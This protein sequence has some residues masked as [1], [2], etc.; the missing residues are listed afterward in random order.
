MA[1]LR[2]QGRR[3]G[4][5]AFYHDVQLRGP[6]PERLLFRLPDPRGPDP[7]TASRLERIAERDPSA[8][9]DRA[10]PVHGY[11]H[12]FA[13]LA[14][15]ARPGEA[16][17]EDRARHVAGA[18]WDAWL[19]GHGRYRPHAWAPALAAA[20]TE[21]MLRH[22]P[23]L[24]EGR[25]APSR[26]AFFG[27]LI[28]QTRH[29]ARAARAR[30]DGARKDGPG[31][32][33]GGDARLA[34][35]TGAALGALCLPFASDQERQVKPLLAAA[36]AGAAGG[37]LPEG[38]RDPARATRLGGSLAALRDAYKARGLTAPAELGPALG[39]PRLLL[40]GLVLPDGGLAVLPGGTEGDRAATASLEPL[41]RP[42]TDALLSRLGYARAL[43]AET[44]LHVDLG[45][46][47][48]GAAAGA[49]CLTDGPDRLVTAAGAP[50]ADLARLDQGLA[51]WREALRTPAAAATLDADGYGPAEA[52]EAA[53]A[54]GTLI[55][56][57]REG[58][59]GGH[60]RRLYLE[61]DGDV[62]R[63]EDRSAPGAVYRFP[64]H[65]GVSVR[66][67]IEGRATL[68]LPGGRSWRFEVASADL[69]A[70]EGI[71][72][73]TGAPEE[74]RQLVVTAEREGVRWA[75]RRV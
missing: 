67:P 45:A 10:S 13:W 5:H 9:F 1:L 50:P 20:R 6:V 29:L 32:A 68:V 46:P 58:P 3:R 55:A 48:E 47:G 44:A 70:E 71:Y 69:R 37:A 25:D 36:L 75:F 62:L 24:L 14:A 17:A 8:F 38:L 65:P 66:G 34:V 51:G 39:L 56:L 54:E 72:A 61:A 27:T 7:L 30:R 21:A 2:E 49:F 64:L 23:L 15:L 18:L 63:G 74:T 40:G 35:L 19:A 42:E 73:G 28:R 53:G 33:A 11:A 52:E 41:R 43:R 16:L 59:S 26:E 4:R 22:A 60:D 31:E 57:R 12:G